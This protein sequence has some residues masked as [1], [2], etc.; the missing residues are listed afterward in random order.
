[1]WGNNPG[2]LWDDFDILLT[3]IF[4]DVSPIVIVVLGVMFVVCFFVGICS[5]EE[6]SNV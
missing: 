1:M 3:A 4:K 5:E 2:V 6:E